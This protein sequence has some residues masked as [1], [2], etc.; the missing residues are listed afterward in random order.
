MKI[1]KYIG[2]I[3]VL[4]GITG[5]YGTNKHVNK[6]LYSNSNEKIN[7]IEPLQNLKSTNLENANIEGKNKN[8][9][10]MYSS[11]ILHLKGQIDAEMVEEFIK[12]F[13]ESSVSPSELIIYIDSPGGSVM[14]GNRIMTLFQNYPVTCVAER[15]Y[16][17]AFAIF[18]MCENRYVLEHSTLMQH[19]MFTIL[20]N[21]LQK[22]NNYLEFLNDINNDL[23][24]KQSKRIGM[25]RN[26]FMEKIYNEWWITGKRA[27]KENVAD[28]LVAFL[29]E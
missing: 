10:T 1:L 3:F 24:E 8:I 12:Q 19:Q 7:K 2:G 16:S 26:K 6:I 9:T 22:L 11:Q 21:E 29:I 15:A 27:V 4:F 14:A 28:S 18:Q 25:S 20:G 23:I 5:L 17:M 13:H